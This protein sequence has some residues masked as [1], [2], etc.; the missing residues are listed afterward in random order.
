MQRYDVIV[1]GAGPAG[2]TAAYSAARHGAKVLLLEEHT[3]IGRPIQ[4]TGLLSLRGWRLSTRPRVARRQGDH[5]RPGALPR[6]L[7]L[8]L[9]GDRVRAY[10][11][12]RDRFDQHLVERAARAGVTVQVGTRAVA[13]GEYQEGARTLITRTPGGAQQPLKPSVII[14]ADDLTVS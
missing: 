11:I 7:G 5:R 14:G 8:R 12:D 1:V 4:C 3:Q 9:G 2:A 10:V 13:L 6:R